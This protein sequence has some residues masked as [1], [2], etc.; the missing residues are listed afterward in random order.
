MSA[1]SS[2]PFF[3]QRGG[4]RCLALEAAVVLV[5]ALL[6]AL[7]A[8]FASPR[9]IRLGRDYFP[10]VSAPL[11]VPALTPPAPTNAPAETNAV[12][13]R[14]RSLGLQP[15][16]HQAVL[17]LFRDPKRIQELF[18]FVDVRGDE[19][20]QAGHIPGA[21]HLNYYH[22]EGAL[23]SVLAACATA[24]K[25]IVYCNGG[26][27]EDSELAAVMLGQAGVPRERIYVYSGGFAEWSAEQLPQESGARLSGVLKEGKP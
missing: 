16:S 9:G 1:G 7:L 14:L 24:E 22:P 19:L 26:E 8:N 25:I 21:Y 27:C 2:Q 18:L 6:V 23:P 12:L 3:C 5:G 4:A 20:Y 10:K 11:V 17:T 15:L 13:A